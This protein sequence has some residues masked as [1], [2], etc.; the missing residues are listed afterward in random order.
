MHVVVTGNINDGFRIM[1]PFEDEYAAEIW[2]REVLD[3]WDS[4]S[5]VEVE[6]VNE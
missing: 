1:G 6:D 5:V 3:P 2:A 4:H